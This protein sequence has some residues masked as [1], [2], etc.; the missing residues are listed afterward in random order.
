MRTEEGLDRSESE[1]E[2]GVRYCG[3]VER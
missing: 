3:R 2:A 1:I